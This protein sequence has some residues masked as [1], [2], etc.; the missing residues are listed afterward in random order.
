[1][2][3]QQHFRYSRT[4]AEVSVY[5]ERRVEIPQVGVCTVGQQPVEQLVCPLAV[6]CPCPEIEFVRS[7]P[8]GG[9]IAPVI[10]R[11]YRRLHKLGAVTVDKA[12][13]VKAHKVGNVA[14]VLLYLRAVKVRFVLLIPF[15]EKS[16]FADRERF[17]QFKLF[18]NLLDKGIIFPFVIPDSQVQE[19][20]IKLRN[21]RLLIGIAYCYGTM[22]RRISRRR[23]KPL[24]FSSHISH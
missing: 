15:F 13:R 9:F 16:R 20:L 6:T 11:G 4:S 17:Q 2:A 8:A 3:L 10:H 19:T 22:F 24:L 21:K 12:S 23:N 18:F 7:R 1:M 5:L 14:V